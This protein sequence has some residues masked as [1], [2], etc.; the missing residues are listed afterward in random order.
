MQVP[1]LGP[2]ASLL[3]EEMAT[4]SGILAWEIPWTERGAWRA[5]GHGVP[6]SRTRL[7]SRA[8]RVV[9][10]PSWGLRRRVPGWQ[11]RSCSSPQ[12]P[13]AWLH[14]SPHMYPHFTRG[15][16]EATFAHSHPAK[17]GVEIGPEPR[18][19]SQAP[20]LL[21]LE[22]GVLAGLKCLSPLRGQACQE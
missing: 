8:H 6:K 5:T 7:S 15:R 19:P 21:L 10:S 14:P 4:H 1:S 20:T 22:E 13:Q 2:E 17:S 3:E 18:V 9:Q 16:V 12:R 11:G